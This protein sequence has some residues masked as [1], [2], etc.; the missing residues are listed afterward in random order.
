MFPR[1]LILTKGNASAR[2]GRCLQEH[3]AS[4]LSEH[5]SRSISIWSSV[6][7]VPGH[8]SV[9]CESVGNSRDALRQCA[10]PLRRAGKIVNANGGKETL[11]I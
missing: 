6:F 5:V 4:C 3:L 11:A 1:A 8:V 7:T 9:R 10:R 2:D